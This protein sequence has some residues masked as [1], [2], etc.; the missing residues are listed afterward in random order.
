MDLLK[1]STI[2]RLFVAFI[3]VVFVFVSLGTLLFVSSD[4]GYEGMGEMV[5]AVDC[6]FGVCE[7]Q[8]SL[9]AAHCFVASAGIS[10]SETIVPI[11]IAIVVAVLV[12]LLLF[13][14]FSKQIVRPP[15]LVYAHSCTAQI[16]TVMKRE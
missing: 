12:F 7:H 8:T 4:M 15:A 1:Q 10:I 16:L 6:D 11:S 9:C 5:Y 3:A 2:H 14:Q 13:S